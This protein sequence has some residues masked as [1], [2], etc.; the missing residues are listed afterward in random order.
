MTVIWEKAINMIKKVKTNTISCIFVK[1]NHN[2]LQNQE[3]FD[4]Y[5]YKKILRG[6]IYEK[7]ENDINRNH[8]CCYSHCS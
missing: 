7:S 1:I 6:E 8:H 4:I 2:F 3:I 5:K